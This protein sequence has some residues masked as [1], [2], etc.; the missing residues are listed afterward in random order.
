MKL[1]FKITASSQIYLPK[2][3]DQLHYNAYNN[4]YELSIIFLVFWL[5]EN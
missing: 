1:V 2:V 3:I 5:F 4:F